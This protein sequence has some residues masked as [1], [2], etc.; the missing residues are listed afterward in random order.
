MSNESALER[1]LRRK[2]VEDAAECNGLGYKP[3]EF[4]RMVEHHGAVGACR[5]VIMDHPY[6]RAPY[7]FSKLWELSALDLTV[8]YTVLQPKWHPLFEQNVRDRAKARL[9]E[10]DPVGVSVRP[11]PE[12]P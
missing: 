7:G 12:P 3:Y 10:F 2:I 1:A 9:H 4:L 11:R 6:N 5:R 8:E